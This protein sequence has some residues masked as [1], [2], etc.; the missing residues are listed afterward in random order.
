MSFNRKSDVKDHLSTRTTQPLPSV[1]QRT[2]T[3]PLP[4]SNSPGVKTDTPEV[5]P[6]HP[7]AKE[8]SGQAQVGGGVGVPSGAPRPKRSQL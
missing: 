3:A 1:P 5:V 7:I 4:E 6:F 8:F 2:N